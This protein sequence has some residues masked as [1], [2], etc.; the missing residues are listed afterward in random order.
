MPFQALAIAAV[1]ASGSTVYR[2]CPLGMESAMYSARNPLL[3]SRAVRDT[4]AVTNAPNRTIRTRSRGRVIQALTCA[5][6]QMR[7]HARAEPLIDGWRRIIE[8]IGAGFTMV[9]RDQPRR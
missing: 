2:I 8:P 9:D 7:A 1:E 4:V 6:L 3:D 5:R